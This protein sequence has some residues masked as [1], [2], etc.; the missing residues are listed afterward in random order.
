[1]SVEL[2]SCMKSYEFIDLTQ[3][4]QINVRKCSKTVGAFLLLFLV[5]R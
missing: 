3:K 1:M 4:N 2:G 5:L